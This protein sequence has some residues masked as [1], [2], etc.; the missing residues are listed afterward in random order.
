MSENAG[1]SDEELAERTREGNADAY[2]QLWKRHAHVG[3]VAANQFRSVD[4]PDD[5]VSE[6]YLRIYRAMQNGGGPTGAFRP[7]LYRTIRNIALDWTRLDRGQPLDTVA[8]FESSHPGP[9]DVVATRTVTARAFRTLPE[10]WQT[11]LWYTEVEG[12]PLADAAQ[13]LGIT[14]NAAGVL[15]HRARA[16]LKK[17]WLQAHVNDRNVPP[18]CQWATDR[19]G[20]S[21]Q[22][23]L[24][25]AD[26]HRFD[27]HIANCARCAIVWEEID[28]LGSKLAVVLFPLVLGGAAGAGMLASLTNERAISAAPSPPQPRVARATIGLAVAV[29]M[30]AIVATAFALPALLT[31][32]TAGITAE[33][34]PSAAPPT[35]SETR[36][37]PSPTPTSTPTPTP[38]PPS[39]GPPPVRTVPPPAPPESPG[40]DVTAP[41]APT[42]D[43]IIGPF[44][45]LPVLSGTAE[46]GALVTILRDG[47]SIGTMTAPGG[48][49]TFDIPDPQ[50]DGTTMAALQTDTAGNVSP[51]SAPTAPIVF[52]RPSVVVPLTVPST[53]GATSVTVELSGEDGASV[54]ILIDGTPTGNIH[55]LGGTPIVR[56]TPP[57]A[58]GIHTIAV[59]YIE[60]GGG[61][62][63]SV[64]IVELAIVP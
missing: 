59:R 53:G 32:T 20:A 6:A 12:M 51:I 4:D 50:A 41:A 13:Y 9:E 8:E 2:A 24:A 15:A 39:A 52:T 29:G 14:A 44:R 63:G 23:A 43:P 37:A 27:A 30:A 33:Q 10:R 11:I 57:L 22:S 35:P 5:M 18:E 31:P 7:Y 45:Y 42:V 16:G 25:A 38:T 40:P 48:A 19:M 36:P 64:V 56:V 54:E 28:D 61:R 26:R 60:P 47:T 46:P 34:H 21:A 62:V 1:P 3:R 58:D 49:W 17:A 55:V